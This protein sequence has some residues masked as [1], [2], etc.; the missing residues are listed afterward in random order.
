MKLECVTMFLRSILTVHHKGRTMKRNTAL[1][2][3]W[4][5]VLATAVADRNYAQ[6]E[7]AAAR[8]LDLQGVKIPVA[9]DH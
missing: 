9:A 8:L 4:L 5:L 1:V 7:I 6:M 2:N 3:G